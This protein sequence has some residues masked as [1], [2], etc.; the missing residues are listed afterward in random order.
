MKLEHLLYEVLTETTS[1]QL[2]VLSDSFSFSM[3]HPQGI[4]CNSRD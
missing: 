4:N 2:I 3:L 1:V